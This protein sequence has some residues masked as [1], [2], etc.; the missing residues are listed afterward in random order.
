MNEW[1]I[2]M[3]MSKHKSPYFTEQGHQ[4]NYQ[5]RIQG[6]CPGCPDTRPLL[7]V[8]FLKRTYFGAPF[9]RIGHPPL[10]NPRSATDYCSS[11]QSRAYLS[12]GF[13]CIV[14]HTKVGRGPGPSMGWVGLCGIFS[15]FVCVGLG[16]VQI[17]VGTVAT[18]LLSAILWLTFVPSCL[19]RK[20]NL[21]RLFAGDLVTAVKWTLDIGF[22]T[23]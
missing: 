14:Q 3:W 17:C 18:F 1:I 20:W 2:S 23:V 16:W 6:G 7:R 11:V 10:P 13:N 21:L 22:E 4:N 12:T 9:W 8:P 15:N 19:L 5:R